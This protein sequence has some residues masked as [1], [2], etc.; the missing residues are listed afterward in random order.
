M[1]RSNEPRRC[2]AARACRECDQTERACASGHSVIRRQRAHVRR[3]PQQDQRTAAM[4][5][6]SEFDFTTALAAAVGNRSRLLFATRSCVVHAHAARR[7]DECEHRRSLQKARVQEPDSRG[8]TRTGVLF[9]NPDENPKL[10]NVD[11]FGNRILVPFSLFVRVP[12][13]VFDTSPRTDLV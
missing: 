9:T 7:R 13:D 5:R 1:D 11:L 8:E 2:A 6:S 12:D 3:R 4:D 10:V